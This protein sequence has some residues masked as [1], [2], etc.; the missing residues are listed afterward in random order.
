MKA[1][2]WN[3]VAGL[4]SVVGVGIKLCV[5]VDFAGESSSSS[6]LDTDPSSFSEQYMPRNLSSTVTYTSVV[7][8]AHPSVIKYRERYAG[9]WANVIPISPFL[10]RSSCFA[11]L[12]I[13]LR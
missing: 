8:S 12:K 1:G 10:N 2:A 7:A 11:T 6:S 3:T 9:A 5:A 4:R 13:S